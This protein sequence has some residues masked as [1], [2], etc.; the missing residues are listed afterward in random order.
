MNQIKLLYNNKKFEENYKIIDYNI[1]DEIK[2][3]Y[4]DGQIDSMW[5]DYLNVLYGDDKI[6]CLPNGETL[7]LSQMKIIF[8]TQNLYYCTP[9]FITKNYV[10]SFDFNAVNN[11]NI[12]YDWL[13]KNAKIIESPELKNY[14]R[15]LFENYFPKIYDFILTNKLQ[16]FD[17]SENFVIKN[18]ISLFDSILPKFNFQEKKIGRKNI[19]I[20]KIDSIK[21][22]TI[23]VFIFASAWVI[24]FFTNYILKTKIEKLISDIF[25]TDDLKGPIFDYFI[26][27]TR[28]DF[29]QWNLLLDLH[30]KENSLTNELLFMPNID[31]IS[32]QWIVDKYVKSNKSIFYTG[33]SCVGKSLIIN[34]LLNDLDVNK[35]LINI[36]IEN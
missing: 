1:N 2:I 17:F 24:S 18:F 35:L 8:E 9:S 25:K 30:L 12:L 22:S 14:I 29:E 20:S 3:L 27:E 23:S 13:N 4:L 31:T 7:N 5:I 32:Y 15:G 34:T 19:T 16:A 33:K 21:K 10:A 28:T 11:Q 26:E 36:I 6:Y